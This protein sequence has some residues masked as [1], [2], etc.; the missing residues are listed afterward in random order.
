MNNSIEEIITHLN[1]SNVDGETMEHIIKSVGMED[2][3]LRQLVMKSNSKMLLEL[4]EEKA[5]LIKG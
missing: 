1:N 5:E 2:Q 3:M 4:I